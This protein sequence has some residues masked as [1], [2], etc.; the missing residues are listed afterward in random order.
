[1]FV[2]LSELSGLHRST[3][4]LDF[5]HEGR[6]HL[7]LARLGLKVNVV[8]QRSRS[9]AKIRV[10]TSLLACFKVGVKVNGQGQISGVLPLILGARLCQVQQRGVITSSKCLSVCLYSVGMCG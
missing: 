9:N 3:H 6:P 7:T 2:C 5:W 10:L 1:M 4:D 8:G